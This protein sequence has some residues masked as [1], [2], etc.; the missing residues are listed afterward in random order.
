[1]KHDDWDANNDHDGVIYEPSDS[2]NPLEMTRV[3]PDV[4]KSRPNKRFRSARGNG[5]R[6]K[7]ATKT[8]FAIFYIVTLMAG[9][10]VC[11]V[12]F[13][14][15]FSN[16][17]GQR[18]VGGGGL[19]QQPPPEIGAGVPGIPD[20]TPQ[21][22]EMVAVIREIDRANNIVTAMEVRTNNNV[23][24][25]VS[26]GV[27][28]QNSRGTNMVLAEFSA[29]DVVRMIFEDNRLSAMHIEQGAIE[30]R[31]TRGFSVDRIS[32]SI[33]RDNASYSYDDN[34]M[35]FYNDRPWDITTIR[36][37]DILNVKGYQNQI[38]FIEIVRSNGRLRLVNFDQIEDGILEISP[39]IFTPLANLEPSLY[40]PQGPHRVL[41]RGSNIE[42]FV[43][44][45]I[46]QTG[47]E[48]VVDLT[49]VQART[50]ALTVRVNVEGYRM[51][52]DDEPVVGQPIILEL[53]TYN[54]RVERDGHITWSQQ[55]HIQQPVTTIAVELREMVQMS[56]VRIDTNPQGADV[57]LNNGF[58]GVSP[59]TQQVP[60]GRHEITVRRAGYMEVTLPVDIQVRDQPYLFTLR[61]APPPT[62]EPA[63]L[64]TPTPIP[65]PPPMPTPTPQ[66]QVPMPT[67]QPAI[68]T[69]FPDAGPP[70][71]MPTQQ[72]G[73]PDIIGRQT[74]P[75]T[76]PTPDTWVNP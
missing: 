1:M 31:L 13:A 38:Y 58:I 41:V 64:P 26:G 52:I 44:D 45:I 50:G 14:I 42:T 60:F 59:L 43:S 62:M 10:T 61:P 65:T 7:R 8:Q 4:S 19:A 40:L 33:M 6:S 71:S 36:P 2:V 67:P 25:F 72:P 28:M 12:I 46:I 68:P 27:T 39:D 55:I 32:R 63:T 37:I 75:P 53:G 66:P 17:M 5:K 47:Q 49:D 9:V 29:G 23:P 74:F 22:E 35:V 15:V 76:N 20:V 57:F 34:I 51:Y 30:Y 54:L 69:P 18:N 11:L 56:T 48:T 70:V 21:I 24:V 3:I 16:M 73:V